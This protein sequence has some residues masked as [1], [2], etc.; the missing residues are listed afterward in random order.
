MKL[1][2]LIF[3][4]TRLLPAQS[5]EFRIYMLEHAIGRERY[6]L[7]PS[8]DGLQL[9]TTIEFTD[10]ANTRKTSASLRMR[11]DYTPLQLA[12]KDKPNSVEVSNGQAIVQ[13]NGSTRTLPLPERYFTIFGETPFAIQMIMFRYWSAHGKPDRLPML[14]GSAAAEPIEIQQT[15][16][17]DLKVNGKSR[18]LNRY[19]VA[20][21]AFGREVV[22]TDADHNLVAAMTFAGGLPTEAVRDDYDPAFAE[23][24]RDGVAQEMLNLRS[25][26]RQVPPEQ[27]GS[28]AITGATLVDG[29][30][31]AP[32]QDSIVVIRNGRILAV[33]P[34]ASIKLPRN[35]RVVEAKGQTLLPGLWEMHIHASGVEFGPALLGA[36]VTTARDCGGEYGYLVAVRNE[37]E[38]G[39]V[40]SP[41]ILLAGLVDAGGLKA[42]GNV[43]AETPEQGRVVVGQYRDA[44]FQ[45]IKLYTYLAPEVVKAISAEAHRLGMTVTGHVPQALTTAEGIGAGMDQI[46]H[47][48]YVSRMMRPADNPRG[49]IDLSSATAQQAIAFLKAHG[50]VVDPT[51]GWGEMAGHSS[52]V[53]VASFEPGILRAPFV[54]EAKFRGMGSTSTTAA[55][56]QSRLQ[57]NLRVILALYKAGIPIVPGS[58]TGLQGYGLLRELELYVKAGLTPLEAIQAATIVSARAMGLDRDSGTIESGKRAD[59]ILVNG[60]PLANI[61]DLRKIS[62]TVT[63]GR[64]YDAQKLR[65]VVGFRR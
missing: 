15:G 24:Y 7:T 31:A 29:T 42:F 17:D 40:P 30:G 25:L 55:Q 10:R 13:E 50:T 37:E 60:D 2:L 6:E 32:I 23:L 28:F 49:P 12:I 26:A 58:D 59:L 22:W 65:E 52:E 39:K 19:T 9:E 14:R 16:Q 63:N 33:G 47:L 43:F 48:N 18:I 4:L 44:R 5:G 64:L 21:L 45:Q 11:G 36:G 53:D 46:N 61:S 51:V 57:E 34:R 35:T 3:V 56:M 1:C 62:M 54:L 41:R 38:Q 27:S 8:A 20:N